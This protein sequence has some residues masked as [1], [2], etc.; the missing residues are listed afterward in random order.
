MP[1][2]ESRSREEWL[3]EVRRRGTRIRRR[4]RV[5]FGVVGA[6]ALVLPVSITAGV[7]R[8]GPERAVELSVAGP[9]PAASDARPTTTTGESSAAGPD[10]GGGV[11]GTAVSG[12]TGGRAPATSPPAGAPSE[13]T[14]TEVHQR[15]ATINGA[16]EPTPPSSVPRRDD[17]VA[18]GD[19]SSTKPRS[20]S[21]AAPTGAG[22]AVESPT[23]SSAA[24]S[25]TPKPCAASDVKVAVT[26]DKAVYAMGEMIRGAFTLERAAGVDCVLEHVDPDGTVSS[27]V[28]Y[29]T[30]NSAGRI[31]E[32]N[33]GESRS[34]FG[35]P[36]EPRKS[37]SF[38]FTWD[39]K[40]CSSAVD[41]ETPDRTACLQVLAG[42]YVFI[43][44]W[45]GAYYGEPKWDAAPLSARASF[46]IGA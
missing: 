13:T 40:D 37:Y 5:G 4:R 10:L 21:A 39:Q 19:N 1:W 20:S 32:Q 6:L 36:F 26:T 30:E 43:G 22:T 15:V 46:Q 12:G 2:T 27:R 7:L 8:V 42:T 23:G 38:G 3:A 44:E 24:P 16:A 35:A 17:P 14:T 41:R 33:G 45:G 34:A 11:I 9:A 18:G 29:H 28:S 31:V 25:T